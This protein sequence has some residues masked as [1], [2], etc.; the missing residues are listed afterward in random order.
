M[1]VHNMDKV[2]LKS[3]MVLRQASFLSIQRT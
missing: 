2:Y 3:T 1:I